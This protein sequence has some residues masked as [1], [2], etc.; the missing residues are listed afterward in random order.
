M[1]T[2]II[3]YILFLSIQ[4]LKK[5]EKLKKILL[6]IVTIVFTLSSCTFKNEK[7][8][9]LILNEDKKIIATWITYYEIYELVECSEKETEFQK[10]VRDKITI[11]KQYNINTI[12]LHVRAFDDCFYRSKYFPVSIYCADKNG[13]LK[14]D[15]LQIFID[16][17]REYDIDVHAWINPY[18]IRND[19]DVNKI[20]DDSLAKEFISD[21]R[22][23]N[24]IITETCITYN[25]ASTEVQKYIVN[26]IKEILDNYDV[27]GIHIDDY[28]Y[29]DDLNEGDIE[30]FN[31][32]QNNG[33]HLSLVDYRRTN[34]NSL[35][36]SIYCLVKSYDSNLVFS[37]SPSADIE[38]NYSTYYADVCLWLQ[39][40]GYIDYIIPQIYYG[41]ENEFL[42]FENVLN[43][44]I[45][46]NENKI[47]IGLGL[48]KA[49]HKDEFAGTGRDE[50]INNNDVIYRQM[51]EI[52]NHSLTGISI[53]SA[54][55]LYEETNNDNLRNEQKS[56][57]EIMEIL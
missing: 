8:K 49:G 41:Y 50:W 19:T 29:P 16:I 28:F 6:I 39:E 42:P 23:E 1:I 48:Y 44:W 27:A 9:D 43:D 55:N 7:A 4:N 47:I 37:I 30:L 3:S 53:F 18:R 40:E 20:S 11:L 36:S 26:G 56:I 45:R 33:G 12:F 14:F 54:S 34:I 57:K 2:V 10:I 25:P 13:E 15:V 46:I 31:K 5:G 38:K 24:I 52:F 51:K 21:N 35:I 17:C 32:Y 22:F